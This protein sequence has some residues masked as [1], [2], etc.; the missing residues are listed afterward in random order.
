LCAAK[1]ERE[2]RRGTEPADPQEGG[3]EVDKDMLLFLFPLPHL[4]TCRSSISISIF[5]DG[6]FFSSSSMRKPG[7][8][9]RDGR[10]EDNGDDGEEEEEST[11]L[12]WHWY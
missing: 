7:A 12:D 2:R 11:G 10:T 8:L 9:R 6:K 1:R 3:T 5:R 4:S